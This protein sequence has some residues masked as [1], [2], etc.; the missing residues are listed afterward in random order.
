MS[1]EGRQK[2]GLGGI[3]MCVLNDQAFAK[4]PGLGQALGAWELTSFI[5]EPLQNICSQ[6]LLQS[7]A[8]SGSR[9]LG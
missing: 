7:L 2:F 1:S 4:L 6:E 5:I 9:A 3:T 8:Q